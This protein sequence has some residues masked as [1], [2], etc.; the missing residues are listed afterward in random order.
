L[1]V[2]MCSRTPSSA[3]CAGVTTMSLASDPH[4]KRDRILTEAV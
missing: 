4:D 1:P 3:L 2:T